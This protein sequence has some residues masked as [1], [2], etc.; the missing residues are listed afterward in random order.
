MDR[1]AVLPHDVPRGR[2]SALP[3]PRELVHRGADFREDPPATGC[4]EPGGVVRLRNACHIRCDESEGSGPPGG[5]P[6]CAQAA[7]PKGRAA[8][9]A[10]SGAERAIHGFGRALP[11]GPRSALRPPSYTVPDAETGEEVKT[12]KDN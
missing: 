4:A 5:L 6:R 8:R 1:R 12:F 9:T 2:D 3:C 10:R 11:S 7:F